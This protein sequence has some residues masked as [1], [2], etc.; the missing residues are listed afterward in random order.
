M[1]ELCYKG[2]NITIYVISKLEADMYKFDFKY[3]S[4][5]IETDENTKLSDDKNRV[6]RLD[7]LFDDLD[8]TKYNDKDLTDIYKEYKPKLFNK[9][10]A[11]KILEFIDKYKGLTIVINCEAGVS[12]SAGV[13]AALSKIYNNEDNWFFKNRC[14]NMLVYRTIL[15]KYCD[16]D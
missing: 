16:D 3:I 14:P 2:K 5:T 9:D 7:L 15:N 1:K 11:T 8:T 6:D 10:M 4:I 12:R 13:G